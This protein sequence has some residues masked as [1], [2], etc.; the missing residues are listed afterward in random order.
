MNINLF[1]VAIFAALGM[2]YIFFSPMKLQEFDKKEIAQ[3]EL[4]NFTIYD[5]DTKGLKS[6]L[7]GQKGYKYEDR[8]EVKDINYTDHTR[9][10]L[11]HLQADFGRY[12]ESVIDL[13]GDVVYKRA[14]GL[15]F[16][17]DK[18]SYNQKTAVFQAPN[19]YTF[20][21]NDDKITGTKLFFDS[22]EN[23]VQSKQITA[24]YQIQK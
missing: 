1:F 3:L 21:K 4:V 17:T 2:I 14:D 16:E 8:Y 24:I 7:H 19:R 10:Y 12:K 13:K 15:T 9:E 20:Y 11:A 23:H 18:A 5:H 6:V 22:K